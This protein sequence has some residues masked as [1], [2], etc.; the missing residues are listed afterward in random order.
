MP[1]C[2]LRVL[3]HGNTSELR[4]CRFKVVQFECIRP[5]ILIWGT[6]D[7]ENFEDLIDFGISHEEWS[8][9]DHFSE[10]APG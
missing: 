5:V 8:A 6:Q 1:L 9:L 7:F 2:I 10:D 4:E 3:N